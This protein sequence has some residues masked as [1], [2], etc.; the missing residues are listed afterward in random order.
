[1]SLTEPSTI[2]R[3]VPIGAEL[4]DS[5]GAHFRVWAPE[6]KSIVVVF[7]PPESSPPKLELQ[8]E[9]TG[10]F[11][12]AVADAQAGTRYKFLVDGKELF[13]TLLPDFSRRVRTDTRRLST[14]LS[15]GR[16]RP[17]VASG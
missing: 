1:M 14:M 8:A 3:S 17:G 13:P 6:H 16:I 4:I 15:S 7:E 9:G 12:G 2:S 11:S 10:Y 5:K